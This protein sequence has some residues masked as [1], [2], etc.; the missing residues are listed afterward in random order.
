M[1]GASHTRTVPTSLLP[2][3]SGHLHS[4]RGLP[5]TRCQS[6]TT[7]WAQSWWIAMA[8]WRRECRLAASPC[9]WRGASATLQCL[10]QASGLQIQTRTELAWPQA[11]RASVRI[12]CGHCSPGLRPTPCRQANAAPPWARCVKAPARMQ[13]TSPWQCAMRAAA[14]GRDADSRRHATLGAL[15]MMMS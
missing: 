13:C 5:A 6:C 14:R 1:V 8:T 11:P 12:S 7:P 2:M 9:R 3:R 10:A 4:L 15:V